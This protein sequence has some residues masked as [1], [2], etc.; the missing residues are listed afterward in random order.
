ML[1]VKESQTGN[2]LKGKILDVLKAY[3]IDINQVFSTTTDNGANM[4]AAIKSVQH[5]IASAD[6]MSCDD[7]E[8]EQADE[9]STSIKAELS[10]QLSLVRCAAHT[11]AVS[12]VI[13]KN[14]ERIRKVT[15]VVKKTRKTKYTLYFEHKQASK[16]PLWSFTR[17][18][19]RYKMVK[20]IVKQEPFYIEL[21]IQYEDIV[22][23]S[24][25][26]LF[27]KNFVAAFTPVYKL[28]KQL[29]NHHVALNDFY[30]QWLNIMRTIENE[31]HNPFCEPLLQAI[32]NRLAKMKENMAFKASLFLDPR[33]N[34]SGSTLFPSVEE[35]NA[36]QVN[37]ICY[38]K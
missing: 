19:G 29:Q 9:V 13:K 5:T 21:G 8:D 30:I 1:E 12:D 38:S 16:A 22:F 10:N 25:D 2:F 24:E 15:N 32:K 26:W 7:D 6:T 18:A 28:T 20:S 14:D 11:L 17:W 35:R 33:F 37:L 31:I 34:F 36:V 3:D 23:S 27:M 4:I